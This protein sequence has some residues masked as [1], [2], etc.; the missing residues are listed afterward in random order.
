MKKY[1]NF[2][3]NLILKKTVFELNKWMISKYSTYWCILGLGDLAGT[4]THLT[5][6]TIWLYFWAFHNFSTFMHQYMSMKWSKQVGAWF[7]SCRKGQ[8]NNLI[9]KSI[10]TCY[11]KTKSSRP[12][13]H[14]YVEYFEIIHLF[15]SFFFKTK[16]LKKLKIFFHKIS[17]KKMSS[18]KSARICNLSSLFWAT[19]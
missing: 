7:E 6:C 17:R 13:M 16:F 8:N 15:N 2:S 1:F 3:R 5:N 10:W 11:L 14:Q 9:W 12:K 19:M 18:K 4:Q